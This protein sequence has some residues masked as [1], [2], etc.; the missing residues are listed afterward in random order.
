[1]A[2]I[3]TELESEVVSTTRV[4]LSDDARF[5]VFN[6]SHRVYVMTNQVVAKDDH[7]LLT[8]MQE[9]A[10]HIGNLAATQRLFAHSDD[11]LKAIAELFARNEGKFVVQQALTAVE[12]ID[13]IT[14]IS[15]YAIMKEHRMLRRFQDD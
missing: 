15:I 9:F 10:F 8:L 13:H 5:N 3:E 12:G 2:E 7:G 11:E 14:G 1:M 6:A 4:N